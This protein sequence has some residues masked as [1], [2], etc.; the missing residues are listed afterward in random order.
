MSTRLS[1]LIAASLIVCAVPARA[2][3]PA[4]APESGTW[5]VG[6][7]IGGGRPNDPSLSGRLGVSANVE[8]YLTPRF[9]IRGQLGGEWS[10]IVN[11]GFTGTLSPVFVDGNA[12]YNWQYS[13]LR[14]Y[15]TGGV[16]IYRYRSSEYLAPTASETSLGVDLGGGLEYVATRRLAVTGE[17]LFHDTG[18]VATPLAM[19]PDGRFWTFTAGVKGFF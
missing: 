12:V 19:F 16:G 1:A 5:A 11:R 18:Q 7:S 13:V 14:P 4:S 8:R 10:D 9:S 15:V 6:G 3:G 2:Q 17:I